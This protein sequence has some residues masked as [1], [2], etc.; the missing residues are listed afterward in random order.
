VVDEAIPCV[1]VVSELYRSPTF[2]EVEADPAFQFDGGEAAS[3]DVPSDWRV[4]EFVH[5]YVL[6]CFVERG[7]FFVAECR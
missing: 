2:V 5:G 6:Y 4:V 1:F 3:D 7:P